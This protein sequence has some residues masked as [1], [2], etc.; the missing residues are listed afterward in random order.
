MLRKSISKT[1][2]QVKKLNFWSPTPQNTVDSSGAPK[3]SIF[4]CTVWPGDAGFEFLRA[5]FAPAP[6]GSKFPSGVASN[7]KFRKVPCSTIRFPKKIF[8]SKNLIVGRWRSRAL[9]A[10]R[11]HRRVRYFGT[12][13]GLATQGSNFCGLDSRPR[14]MVRNFRR[15]WRAPE[16]LEK[17]L[18]RKFRKLP[19]SE[20]RFP[21]QTFRSKD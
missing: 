11:E 16:N 4:W 15:A 2:V 7:R 3:G 8:N 14:Q 18:A 6:E 17:Y 21:R 20:N 5:R 9:L 1:D 10:A 13:S 12:R 19:C